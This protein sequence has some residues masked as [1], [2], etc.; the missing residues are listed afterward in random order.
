MKL[1]SGLLVFF[2][3]SSSYARWV[4]PPEAASRINFER[5]RYRVNKDGTYALTVERQLE[6]LKDNART[7]QGLT[8][9][10]FDSRSSDFEL[11]EAKTI[12]PDGDHEVRKEHIEVKPLASAGPGFD[13]HRQITIAY[14]RVEVGSKLFY[15]YRRDIK[16]TGVRGLFSE[17][18]SFGWNELVEQ[19]ELAFESDIPL[20]HELVDPNGAL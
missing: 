1:L 5:W 6:I 8:R 13:E 20:Y 16:K 10:T 15:R 19:G 11:L 9:L 17:T 14:P 4:Q 7:D 18:F 3:C 2:L 12:N